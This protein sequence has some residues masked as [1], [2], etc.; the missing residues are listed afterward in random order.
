MRLRLAQLIARFRWLPPRQRTVWLA[1]SC[2]ALIVLVIT[3]SL[4]AAGFHQDPS[5]NT[6]YAPAA[7]NTEVA[8]DT[9]T[10]SPQAVPTNTPLRPWSQSR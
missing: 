9:A 4:L 6:I 3:G 1:T 5:P 2:T 7:T 8:T 10:S